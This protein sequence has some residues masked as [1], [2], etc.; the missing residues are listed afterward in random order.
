MDPCFTMGFS[1]LGM[2]DAWTTFMDAY[3]SSCSRIY[4]TICLQRAYCN[5]GYCLFDWIRPQ[6]S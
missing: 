2:D 6:S 1:C 4:V 3:Y 5:D